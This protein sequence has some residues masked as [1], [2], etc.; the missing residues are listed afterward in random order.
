MYRGVSIDKTPL[1]ILYASLFTVTGVIKRQ[2][3][4]MAKMCVV[5]GGLDTVDSASMDAAKSAFVVGVA[6]ATTAGGQQ[7]LSAADADP[8]SSSSSYGSMSS[9]L[10]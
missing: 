5:Q 6:K 7:L 2:R 3:F 8:R 9:S 1:L 10:V 4:K